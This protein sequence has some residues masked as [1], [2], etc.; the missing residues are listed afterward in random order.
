[1]FDKHIFGIF[2]NFSPLVALE[3]ST[4]IFFIFSFVTR[5]IFPGARKLSIWFSC[6]LS[7]Q[8]KRRKRHR[9]RRKKTFSPFLSL[10]MKSSISV[11]WRWQTLAVNRCGKTQNFP[12]YLTFVPAKFLSL[13]AVYPSGISRLWLISMLFTYFRSRWHHE[14]PIP[15]LWLNFSAWRLILFISSCSPI[16]TLPTTLFPSFR[17][18]VAVL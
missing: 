14:A 10:V 11:T 12:S 18:H 6:Q 15:S 13:D 4:W 1:M 3:G 7:S 2:N 5:A 9:R 8:Q 16:M 17:H